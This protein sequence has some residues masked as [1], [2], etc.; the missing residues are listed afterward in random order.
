MLRKVSP[1]LA[2]KVH[3]TQEKESCPRKKEWCPKPTKADGTASIGT[4][5][6]FVLPLEFY[7]PDRKELPVAQ[8][9]FGPQPVIF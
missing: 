4:K 5:M 6:V 3:C 1:N 8:L 2:V 9:D 7:A